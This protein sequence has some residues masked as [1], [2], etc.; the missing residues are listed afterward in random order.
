MLME[1][2]QKRLK[3][4]DSSSRYPVRISPKDRDMRWVEISAI[5]VEW[6]G[7]PATL[8]FLTDITDRKRVI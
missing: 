1:R 8:K 5:V 6:E 3:G 2:Y 7:R 4:E